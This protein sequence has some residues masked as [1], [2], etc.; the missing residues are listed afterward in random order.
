MHR[1]N[2]PKTE[3]NMKQRLFESL[4]GNQFKLISENVNGSS[5]ADLVR[6]GLRKV[7]NAG[8][9]QMTYEFI[10]NIGLGYI[11]DVSEARKCAIEEARDL[12]GVYGYADDS[13]QSKFVKEE[14]PEHSETD[15]SNPEERTE[16]DIGRE[17]LKLCVAPTPS[18]EDPYASVED[19]I[20]Q[21]KALAKELIEMHGQQPEQ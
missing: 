11:K 4:G 20:E 5:K 15:M 3:H 2:N 9:K 16:V 12:A 8:H 13:S 18:R 17:I 21:I 14:T 7:F 10:Q 19:N 1:T 6:E